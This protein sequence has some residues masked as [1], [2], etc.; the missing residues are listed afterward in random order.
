MK[1]IILPLWPVL[2][3]AFLIPFVRMAETHRPAIVLAFSVGSAIS[4][5]MS[6]VLFGKRD[7]LMGIFGFFLSVIAASGALLLVYKLIPGELFT[8]D[9]SVHHIFSVIAVAL[10]ASIAEEFIF[11]GAILWLL[12]RYFKNVPVLV[13][14]SIQAILFAVSHKNSSY[15][16]IILTFSFGMFFGW[17]AYKTRSLWFPIGFHFGWDVVIVFATGFHSLNFGH[18][19]GSV[20]FNPNFPNTDNLVFL[21]ALGLSALAFAKFGGHFRSKKR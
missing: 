11:R 16:F 6:Y 2:F 18:I 4:V 12:L 14:L 19:K 21:S 7:F 5:M 8:P 9:F 17:T 15:I 13:L 10:M 1:R 20:I 3:F